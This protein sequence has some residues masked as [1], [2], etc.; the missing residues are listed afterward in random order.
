MHE[1]FDFP[2]IA[3]YVAI[4]AM[5][6]TLVLTWSSGWGRLRQRIALTLVCLGVLTICVARIFG[7]KGANADRTIDIYFGLSVIG[8]VVAILSPRRRV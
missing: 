2:V 4:I 6:V 1:T 8:V 3:S 5:S 7:V